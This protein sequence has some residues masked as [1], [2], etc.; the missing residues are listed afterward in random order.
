[1]GMSGASGIDEDMDKDLM[2]YWEH[3]DLWPIPKDIEPFVG[4]P[5]NDM[6]LFFNICP[7]VSFD[8]F[9]YFAKSL[10]KYADEIDRDAAHKR[11]SKSNITPKHWKWVW[12]NIKSQHYT[13][14]EMYSQL[15]VGVQELKP[16]IKKNKIGF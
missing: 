16:S 13:E 3:T 8:L 7:E 15:L 5:E 6:H 4:G 10:S 14:C 2:Q 12:S 9:G 1:M 11:L